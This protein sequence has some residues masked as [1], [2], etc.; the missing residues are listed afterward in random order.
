MINKLDYY[1]HKQYN[2]SLPQ[3]KAKINN[4]FPFQIMKKVEAAYLYGIT[5]SLSS[6]KQM[7][8]VFNYWSIPYVYVYVLV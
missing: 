5:N 2:W 7:I 6:W 1:F 8:I 4:D 3:T